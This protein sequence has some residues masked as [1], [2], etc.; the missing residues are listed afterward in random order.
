MR[1]TLAALLLRRG[2]FQVLRWSSK[3]TQSHTVL[4]R[5]TNRLRG[6]HFGQNHSFSKSMD[7]PQETLAFFLPF[8]GFSECGTATSKAIPEILTSKSSNPLHVRGIFENSTPVRHVLQNK[9]KTNLPFRIWL[10]ISWWRPGRRFL[11]QK[12]D[13]IDNLRTSSSPNWWFDL[14]W[15]L[16]FDKKLK[17]PTSSKTLCCK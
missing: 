15:F 2:T 13:A 3:Y 12:W 9:P 6:V 4:F 10:S 16:P 11:A 7:F 17:A 8:W 5:E 14:S 1:K